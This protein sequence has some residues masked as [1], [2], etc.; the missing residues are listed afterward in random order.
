MIIT[1]CIVSTTCSLPPSLSATQAEHSIP[2]TGQS[3][4]SFCFSVVSLRPFHIIFFLLCFF[5]ITSFENPRKF[6]CEKFKRTLNSH[7]RQA[8]TCAFETRVKK[9]CFY[10]RF[11]AEQ[12]GQKIFIVVS[13]CC[14]FKANSPE[15]ILW[16]I[17]SCD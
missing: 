1:Q 3:K 5:K 8:L 15:S 6:M 14:Y 9:C 4:L 2:E 13:L 7:H 17:Q 10:K 12:T 11:I 16:R